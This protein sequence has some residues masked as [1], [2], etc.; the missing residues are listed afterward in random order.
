M[1]D[2]RKPFS[3]FIE[4]A[5]VLASEAPVEELFGFARPGISTPSLSRAFFSAFHRKEL[6]VDCRQ[7]GEVRACINCS[8]CTDICPVDILPSFTLK[9]ILADEIEEAAAHGLLDC[10]ECGLCTF[11]C[12]AKINLCETF[13]T[14]KANYLKELL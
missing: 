12:P 3:G 6:T 5:L 10:A 8:Y 7:H 4:N 2:P 11:V 14:A 1:R 9:C 13:K